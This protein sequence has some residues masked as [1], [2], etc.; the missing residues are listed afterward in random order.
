[1]TES[2]REIS[3]TAAA[4]IA[5][6]SPD[7]V[8]RWIQEGAIEARRISPRGWWKVKKKSLALYLYRLSGNG[9]L[10]NTANSARISRAARRF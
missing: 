3:V 7:T 10:Q 5:G 2:S 6:C 4:R 1:M 8:L 9:E